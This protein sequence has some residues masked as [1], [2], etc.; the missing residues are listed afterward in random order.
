MVIYSSSLCKDVAFELIP[1]PEANKIDCRRIVTD[2]VYE[3]SKAPKPE[4]I[5]GEPGSVA[6]QDL[7]EQIKMKQDGNGKSG[8]PLDEASQEGLQL[9]SAFKEMAALIEEVEAAKHKQLDDILAEIDTYFQVLKPYMTESQRDMFQKIKDFTDGKTDRLNL[10][11][12]DLNAQ[13][14]EMDAIL[15]TLFG[16]V[17]DKEAKPQ[18]GE[19][20]NHQKGIKQEAPKIMNTPIET[21]DKAAQAEDSD[22]SGDA[23]GHHSYIKDTHEDK[24]KA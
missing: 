17:G 13:R 6:F 5:E 12:Q 15:E 21:T 23:E 9:P 10:V 20:H 19:A 16:K 4:A 1:A 3:R 18:D 24:K 2:E 14:L 8:S 11:E 7:T 22:T